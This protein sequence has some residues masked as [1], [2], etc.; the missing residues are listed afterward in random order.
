[1]YR[2]RRHP[3]WTDNY[4]LFR[5]RVVTNRLTQRQSVNV[6]YVK[7]TI[8][9]LLSKNSAAPDLYFE[10]LANDKQKELEMNEYWLDTFRRL[11]VQVLDRVDKKQEG[12]YGRSFMKLNIVD[13]KFHMQVVDPQD[14]LLDRF[15]LPWDIESARHVTHVGIYRTLSDL[16]RS[17][18]YNQAAINELKTFFGTKLGIIKA[19]ENAQIVA[20]RNERLATMGDNDVQDPRL[21]ETYVELNETQIRVWDETEQEDVTYV[22]VVAEGR[23]I[24]EKP[25]REILNVNFYTWATWAGDVEATDIW[26]DGAADVARSMN[27]LANVR[28]SQK[29][30]NGTLHNWGMQFYD[31][32]DLDGWTPV[33]YQPGPFVFMPFPGDPNTKMR[34]VE[35]PEMAD[36]FQELDWYKQQ[37]E[38]ATAATS[39]EKGEEQGGNSTLGE[40][41]LLAAQ[42]S[43]RITSGSFLY[44]QYWQDIG[45]KFQ[46]M[47][48]A[49][50]DLLD[51]VTL[52]KKSAGGKFYP[53]TI[54]PS[55]LGSRTGYRCRVTS[56]AKKDADSLEAIQKLKI[57]E[58]QFP[59]NLPLQTI[60][61]K[62]VLDWMALTPD[63]A[64]E[65]MDFDAQHP[66]PMVD[67][68]AVA[69]A[70]G[71]NNAKRGVTVA[72]VINPQQVNAA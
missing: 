56:K 63:E 66:M 52:H 50:P 44:E 60:M 8:A 25:L 58:A 30:E 55:R 53:R 21:G 15:M 45:D 19:G 28:V 37:I 49:N 70:G 26:S 5:D 40:I 32:T 3:E 68:N 38:G 2:E 31:S 48:N 13:G 36:V 7:E 65:V 61:K 16:E 67:P 62:K 46:A 71:V 41:Q 54:R 9:T 22:E 72:D 1:L 29:A 35:I 33:G 18:L 39:I 14:V 12:L 69:A 59:G 17:S 47:V 42:A 64:K 51:P 57:G 24:L 34:R 43:K 11:K 27:Q 20:E 23:K 6:P 10:D 4:L